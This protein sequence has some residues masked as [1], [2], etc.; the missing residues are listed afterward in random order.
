MSASHTARTLL[1]ERLAKQA[2]DFV[3]VNNHIVRYIKM[4]YD[5]G[6][7]I[8]TALEELKPFDFEKVRPRLNILMSTEQSIR[9]AENR[10]YELN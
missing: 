2:G 5:N 10:Q 4:N 9:A 3:T 1:W 6:R 8:G 7:D